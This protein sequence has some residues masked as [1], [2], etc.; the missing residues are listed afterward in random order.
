MNRRY[1]YGVTNDE[2]EQMLIAQDGR[3]ALCPRDIAFDH[4][5]RSRRP[6]VDHDHSTGK[7]RG[8]L[9]LPCNTGIG[10][11]Q[12]SPSLLEK[13]AAYLRKH[14]YALDETGAQ[15]AHSAAIEQGTGAVH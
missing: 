9:C 13:A 4:P 10:L 11:L 6:N 14:A 15:S 5:R 7:I 1:V 2:L 12:D 3:C 8:L